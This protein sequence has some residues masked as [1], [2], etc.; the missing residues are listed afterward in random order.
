MSS[1]LP[2]PFKK[3]VQV[4]KLTYNERMDQHRWD[5]GIIP[6]KDLDD[7]SLYYEES[8]QDNTIKPVIGIRPTT[9]NNW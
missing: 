5:S 4:K 7:F 6:Y 9:N 2:R 8:R 1:K 3:R